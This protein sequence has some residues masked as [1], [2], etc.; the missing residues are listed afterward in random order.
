MA[1]YRVWAESISDV[2]L[3]VEA[4]SK[5]EAYE[6]A[7]NADGGDFKEDLLGGAWRLTTVQELENDKTISDLSD[8]ILK[9]VSQLRWDRDKVE[10][11]L[12]EIKAMDKKSVL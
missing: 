3:D 8:E 7:R 2:Y 11:L 1:K 5:E 12:E 6:I 10:S 9:E 4:N